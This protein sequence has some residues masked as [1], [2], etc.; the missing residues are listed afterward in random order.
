MKNVSL[1]T[2]D[3]VLMV[4]GYV[5]SIVNPNLKGITFLEFHIR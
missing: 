1:V 2:M 3:I 5:R 4:N